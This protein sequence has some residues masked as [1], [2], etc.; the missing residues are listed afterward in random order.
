M[1]SIIKNKLS[2]I[3]KTCEQMQVKSL[4]LFGSGV[5]NDFNNNSDFDFLFSFKNDKDGNL[6]PP[7]FDYFDLMFE[8][9]KI[10]GRKVD[11]V[12]EQEVRNKYFLKRISAEKIKIYES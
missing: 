4:Y 9:E 1:N 10:T 11:L 2:D 6:L 8:L 5:R 7:Y 12:A 3:I